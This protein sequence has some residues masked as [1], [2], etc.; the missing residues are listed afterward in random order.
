MAYVVGCLF[1]MNYKKNNQIDLDRT[2][3]HPI[4]R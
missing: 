4:L 1:D 3:C 2:S